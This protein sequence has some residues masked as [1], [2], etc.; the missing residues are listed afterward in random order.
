MTALSGDERI[1]TIGLTVLTQYKSAT[2]GQ[3]DRQNCRISIS[4]VAFMNEIERTLKITVYAV[5]C[6][7]KT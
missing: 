5:H 6:E 7:K 1:S 4:R 2:D 3:T